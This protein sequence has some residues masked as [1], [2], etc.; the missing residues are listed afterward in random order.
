M[1]RTL[2]SLTRVA[3]AGLSLA[4][5]L[6]A[7]SKAPDAADAAPVPTGRV[8]AGR[9]AAIDQE[10]GQWL[11]S[12]RDAGKT[13]YSPLDQINAET[14]SRLGFAWQ[15]ETGTNRGMQATPI[16]VDGVMYTS[17]VAGRVYAL[18]AATG[19]A[20]WRF[21]PQVDF[22]NVRSACCDIV[23]RGVSVWKGRVYVATFDGILH[24]LDARDG[25]VLWQV[26]TLTDKTRGYS[27]TGAPQIAGRN[28]VI[29]NGG[30][31]YDSRGYVTAYDLET[32]KQAWRF[33]IVP[34]D[35]KLGP[36]GAASD[37]IMARALETWHGTDWDRGGGGNAWDA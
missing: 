14:V 31:E 32:G 36:E 21:E 27:V 10:P 29:G 17:G 37:G 15:F 7:C 35:P 19:E 26:D 25:K 2:P 6:A 3:V 11:T 20:L 34:R 9:L 18:D 30:A 16:V 8:E 23:N 28:V 24:S 5:V 13:F 22:K 12:G 1:K 33:Y 4:A